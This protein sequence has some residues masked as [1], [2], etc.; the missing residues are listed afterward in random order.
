MGI[1]HRIVNFPVGRRIQQRRRV[2]LQAITGARLF[3]AGMVN[4]ITKAAASVGSTPANVHAAV[5]LLKA[6]NQTLIAKVLAG[7]VSL[8]RAAKQARRVADLVAAYRAASEADIASAGRIIN[9]PTLVA[10]E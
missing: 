3:A 7:D 6:E 2:A 4:S 5:I 1:S 8:M 10:A 9:Q